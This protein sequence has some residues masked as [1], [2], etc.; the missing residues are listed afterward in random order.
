VA[1][2]FALQRLRRKLLPGLPGAFLEVPEQEVLEEEEEEIPLLDSPN[3]DGPKRLQL[4]IL[5]PISCR[6]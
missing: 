6:T 4:P 5:K 3:R 1:S 2:A